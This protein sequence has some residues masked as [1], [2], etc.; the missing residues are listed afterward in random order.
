MIRNYT[1]KGNSLVMLAGW[2]L[3]VPTS[4]TALAVIPEQSQDTTQ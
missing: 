1:D 3:L 2:L 4:L